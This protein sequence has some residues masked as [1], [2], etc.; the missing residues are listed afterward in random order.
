MYYY[1]ILINIYLIRILIIQINNNK[2]INKKINYS[3]ARMIFRCCP[4]QG[5]VIKLLVTGMSRKSM[6]KNNYWELDDDID[7]IYH[8]DML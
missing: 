5:V 4:L 3:S 2:K 7:K 6:T 8:V 1:K